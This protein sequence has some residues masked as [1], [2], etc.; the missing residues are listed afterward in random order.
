MKDLRTLHVAT[1][2]ALVRKVDERLEV[3]IGGK[4]VAYVRLFDLQA[5]HLYARAHL[6]VSALQACN[7]AGVRVCWYSGTRLV[8][9]CEPE[10]PSHVMTRISQIDCWRDPQWL[11]AAC[12]HIV[13]E[14]L[15]A[16]RALLLRWRHNRGEPETLAAL[17][18]AV[19]GI[20]AALRRTETA[21][22]IEAA[23]GCEGAG[24]AAYFG[25]L[26]AVLAT[27]PAAP[28]GF[29]CRRS[30]PPPDPV[31]AVLSF[32]Y[33]LLGN[34]AAGQ[35]EAAGLDPAI[36]ILHGLRS[37]R[38]SLALDHIEPYRAPVV[39]A[40]CVHLLSRGVLGPDDFN[41]AG[42]GKVYLS[43]D[44]RQK[45]LAAWEKWLRSPFRGF[46]LFGGGVPG[47]APAD[48][49][50]TALRGQALAI[51]HAIIHRS[52]IE[53]HWR[54]PV[55]EGLLVEVQGER[56]AALRTT[57]QRGRAHSAVHDGS[58][59]PRRSAGQAAVAPKPRTRP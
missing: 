23:R 7:R 41:P 36:G 2:G 28:L 44:G 57:S 6:T 30:H 46:G 14:K 39:D 25:G 29:R 45:F 17:A 59:Q 21:A 48:S 20:E 12:R 27:G 50:R 35:L 55:R 58:G 11:L 24:A 5:V 51:R 31:N 49:W 18:L 54:R 43:P 52:P 8:S 40:L 56:P 22:D 3:E 9:R 26:A 19:G 47:E 53:W 1:P 34:E 13:A 42:H 15:R 32:G 38:E 16:S 10:H 37:G 4:R 33:T